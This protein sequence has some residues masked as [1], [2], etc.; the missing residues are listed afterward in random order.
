MLAVVTELYSHYFGSYETTVKPPLLLDGN[1]LMKELGL[2]P[3]REIGRLLGMIQEAQ[4]AGEISSRPEAVE[5][6]RRRL[7][8]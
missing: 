8:E 7:R 2:M 4:A 6:A 1:Q 5:F 3:G